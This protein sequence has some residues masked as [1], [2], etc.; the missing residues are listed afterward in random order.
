VYDYSYDT[1]GRLTGVEYPDGRE[2]TY[3]YNANNQ[4]LTMTS[5][6]GTT[7]YG[8]DALSRLTSVNGTTFEYDALGLLTDEHLSNGVTTSYGYD[9][10]NRLTNITQQLGSTL[11]GS[12]AYTLDDAGNRLSVNEMGGQSI[13]WTYDDLYRLKSETRK[14]GA[15]IV[16]QSSFTY[17]LTGNRLSQ[18]VD[19]VTTNYTYNSLDQM[20][21]AGSVQYEYDG[22]GN[23]K[24]EI[25]G[26]QIAQ[27]NYDAAN[28]LA[29]VITPDGMTIT[30]SFDADGRRVK[31][32]VNAQVTTYLWD[33]TSLYGDVV[34]ETTGG[35]NTSYTLAGTQLISQTRNGSISFYLQDGQGSTRALTNSAGAVTDTYSYTAYGEIYNQT[36]TTANNYLYTGQQFDQSTGLYSL[37]ARFYNPSWGRFLSQ[38]T[39]AVNYSNPIELNR[40]GYTANNP[41]NGMDPSGL[42]LADYALNAFSKLEAARGFVALGMATGAIYGYV[43]A[44]LCGGSVAWGIASGAVMGGVSAIGMTLAP[45]FTAAAGVTASVIG[46]GMAFNDI[47]QH[48]WNACNVM[49]AFT[50]LVGIA[51]GVYGGMSGGSGFSP[52]LAWAGNNGYV[53]TMASTAQGGI[54]GT[55]SILSLMMST[56]GEGENTVNE[57]DNS[58]QGFTDEELGYIGDALNHKYDNMLNQ[59]EC[60]GA[61]LARLGRV[62]GINMVPNEAGFLEANTRFKLI[63]EFKPLDIKSILRPGDLITYHQGSDFPVHS[64]RF[65]GW[66]GGKALFFDKAGLGKPFMVN[67]FENVISYWSPIKVLIYRP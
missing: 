27:Y 26:S 10:L 65:L 33:E 38:D 28:R 6:G 58:S 31:Q 22:R 12:Y 18:T 15:T 54:E 11:I 51:G 9:D 19:G 40:Y 46:T 44:S 61:S 32:T 30:N 4:I 48:G 64:N 24:K 50:S 8:Y 47:A 34:L 2:I 42:F 63:G 49:Q 53:Y 7:S 39:W 45:A 16:A 23:L 17:D 20:L 43:S 1:F 59:I 36:G 41:I 67:S 55:L 29:S 21:T 5:P 60:H 57:T 35:V 13:Q 52:S 62:G 37:R 14:N 56:G 66:G 25:D 3:T